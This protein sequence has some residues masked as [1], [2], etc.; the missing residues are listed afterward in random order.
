MIAPRFK[1]P[2]HPPRRFPAPRACDPAKTRFKWGMALFLVFCAIVW[3]AA[4]D[5]ILNLMGVFK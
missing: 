3:A 4:I 2:S 5:G 1:A